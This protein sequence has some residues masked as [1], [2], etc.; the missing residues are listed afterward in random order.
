MEWP[1]TSDL[2]LPHLGAKIRRGRGIGMGDAYIPWLKVRDVPSRGTSSIV[3]GINVDRPFHFLSK[4]EITYFYLQERKSNVIDIRE[5]FPILDIARTLELCSQFGVTHSYR[6]SYP[7]PFTIDFLIT[8]KTAEGVR[9]KAAS[10]KTPED[11]NDARV[12]LRL[13]IE[14]EWCREQSIPW[15]LIDTS[16]FNDIVLENL[17]FLRSWFRHRYIPSIQ[18]TSTFAMSFM[19]NYSRNVPLVELLKRTASQLRL[20]FSVAGDAFRYC[21]WTNQL[22]V[23]LHHSISFDKPLVLSDAAN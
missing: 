1:S 9:Y 17:R 14:Y 18:K 21:G 16:L 13:A 7:E 19:N 6:G 20:E 2:Y 8:E 22:P 15:V 23:S 3:R 10:I 11:A 5:Q 4:L 12:A